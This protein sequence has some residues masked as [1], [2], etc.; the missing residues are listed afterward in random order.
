MFID[1]WP[2]AENTCAAQASKHYDQRTVQWWKKAWTGIHMQ[3]SIWL[4]TIPGR[5][6]SRHE[7]GQIFGQKFRGS[8]LWKKHAFWKRHLYP[9]L[10]SLHASPALLPLQY[11]QAQ[12][13]SNH[14]WHHVGD[15]RYPTPE[16]RKRSGRSLDHRRRVNKGSGAAISYTV[17]S[18]SVIYLKKMFR[19]APSN[20]RWT[21]L[22]T[23]WLKTLSEFSVHRHRWKPQRTDRI[24]TPQNS[25][26]MTE[27]LSYQ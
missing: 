27:D 18:L 6:E 19:N 21:I 8:R 2:V 4:S 12:W 17:G 10:W 20:N 5:L 24:L 14:Y 1:S 25:E 16:F 7:F 15:D 23:S 11:M 13:W 9:T 3:F 22:E 26:N